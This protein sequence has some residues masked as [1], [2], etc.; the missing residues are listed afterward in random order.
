[1]AKKLQSDKMQWELS[2]KDSEAQ[3][4][5]TSL[6]RANKELEKSNK[7]I[8]LEMARLEAQGKRN[9]QEYIGLQGVLKQNNIEISHNSKLIKENESK[10]GLQNMTMNQLRKRY[11]ELQ[12][13]MNNTSKAADPKAWESLKSKLDET[14]DAM[15]NLN[16][17]TQGAE[18]V[19]VSWGSAMKLGL[20]G[21][22]AGLGQELLSGIRN[23]LDFEKIIKSNQATGDKYAATMA[24]L[25]NA[26]DTFRLSLA[27]MDFSNF[28][29][30]LASAYKVAYDVAMILDELFERQNSF[31][32]QDIQ[33]K[34][35]IEDLYEVMNN[36]NLSYEQRKS[37]AERIQKLTN[38]QA[39]IQKEIYKSEADA[40][41]SNLVDRTKLNDTQLEF[42]IDQ[43]NANRGVITQAREYLELQQK[44]TDA[45]SRPDSFVTT[46][47]TVVDYRGEKIENIKKAEQDLA[48]YIKKIE[49]KKREELEKTE[50]S[51]KQAGKTDKELVVEYIEGIKRAAEI[52]KGYDKGNDE[53]VTKYVESRVK[54]LS[55][56]VEAAKSLR[57]VINNENS[58][59]KGI[60]TEAAARQKEIAQQSLK[61]QEESYNKEIAA[62]QKANNEKLTGYKEMLIAG[63]MSQEEYNRKLEALEEELVE[64][65]IEI[66]MVYSKSIDELQSQLLD[67]QIE[68]INR[69]KTKLDAIRK[70]IDDTLDKSVEKT[71]KTDSDKI[72]A[73]IDESL[74]YMDTAAA[75]ASEYFK[76]RKSEL[77]VQKELHSA[78]LQELQDALDLKMLS[79]EQYHEAV[80]KLDQESWQKRFDINSKGAKKVLDIV[81]EALAIA[82]SVITQMQ[83][84]EMT[85]LEGQKQ[86][87]LSLYGDSYEKRAEIE[88]KYEEKKLEIQQKYAD[89]DMAV[90]IAQALANG[91][92]G[93]MTAIAQ[94]GPLAG[95]AIAI[96]SATT[97]AQV[98]MIAAQRMAIKNTST[99]AGR[100]SGGI[101]TRTVIGSQEANATPV[102]QV[103]AQQPV[104]SSQI[105]AINDAR[106]ESFTGQ[107]NT[108][109][110][111]LGIMKELSGYLKDLRDNPIAAYTV[112]SQ[113][114]AKKDQ[115]ERFK[116][117]G[118]L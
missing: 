1:M 103:Q 88:Q 37:A 40:H 65:K 21:I 31:R 76:E 39:E 80:K 86:R 7:Q 54:M 57:R 14:K 118:S 74:S 2:I 115:L 26:F 30:K 32:I 23:L 90:K 20:V 68:R 79:E 101:G 38:E 46:K 36:V 73:E 56:D 109:N 55:V 29:E 87:E 4:N 94:L 41:K 83:E 107:T 60:A 66:N 82:S 16:H 47:G 27:T 12:R 104:N 24:G 22:L 117:E 64:K 93:I 25:K 70:Q 81:S 34:A 95:P 61:Q 10:L 71:F 9:S 52:A 35:E 67:R 51:K 96:I 89:M 69:F 97:A 106:G 48:A 33:V 75:K 11:Q 78:E 62:A 49:E 28:N 102:A 84:V 114:E 112:L 91:A 42:Y 92:L 3:R 113:H 72:S 17:Q 58:M 85:K 5:I 19:M 110:A 77:D 43:Y 6:T 108:A 116:K 15:D 44:I 13:E 100:S 98:A 53:F 111:Q 59:L 45:R 8:R 18:K 99:G 50:A 63:H 105:S